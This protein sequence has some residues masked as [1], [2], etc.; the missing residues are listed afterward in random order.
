MNWYWY[1]FM[2][3]ILLYYGGFFLWRRV[4]ISVRDISILVA[5]PQFRIFPW[6]FH[7]VHMAHNLHCRRFGSVPL[8]GVTGYRDPPQKE[9]PRYF[10]P[11]KNVRGGG[12]FFW[13]EPT[14]ILILYAKIHYHRFVHSILCNFIPGGYFFRGSPY[15]VTPAWVFSGADLR[16]GSPCRTFAPKVRFR[17]I[18]SLPR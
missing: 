5:G 3:R 17:S 18:Y 7:G 16:F 8:A 10:Y 4:W 9:Y 11:R 12:Y 14:R 2:V 15:I 6:W 13:F 1:P